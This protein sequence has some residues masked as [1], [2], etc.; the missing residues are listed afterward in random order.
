[1]TAKEPS[2]RLSA[3]MILNHPWITRNFNSFIPMTC[4]ENLQAFSNQKNF[5]LV[6]KKYFCMNELIDN[7]DNKN[8]LFSFILPTKLS[9]INRKNAN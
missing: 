8:D 6:F 7:L 2:D 3:E 4:T 1:M 9:K 5:L